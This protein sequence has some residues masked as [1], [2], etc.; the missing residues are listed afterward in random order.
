MSYQVVHPPFS[1]NFWEMPKEEL[2]A[3]FAWLKASIP[4]RIDELTTFIRQD[5]AHAEWQPDYSASSL[6][7]LGTWLS[8]HLSVRERTDEELKAIGGRSKHPIDIPKDALTGESYS[9]AFDVGMYLAMTL[10]HH[11]PSLN[12]IQEFKSRKNIDFGQPLLASFGPVPLN[13]VRIA[14]NIAH[15][16]ARKERPPTRLREVYEEWSR[17]AV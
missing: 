13:P 8:T 17:R 11:H 7:A 4:S 3:Y 2:R 10:I 5:P 12:W 1:L 16:L 14:V 6:D 15:G 9:I